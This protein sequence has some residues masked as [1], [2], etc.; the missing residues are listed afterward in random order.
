MSFK[1]REIARP[2]APERDVNLRAKPRHPNPAAPDHRLN[3][4]R[5][6]DEADQFGHGGLAG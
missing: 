2:L 3:T 5:S 6:H 4:P 1:P